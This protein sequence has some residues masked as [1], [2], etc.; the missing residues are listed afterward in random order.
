MP[1]VAPDLEMSRLN[2]S[3]FISAHSWSKVHSFPVSLNE[4][5]ELLNRSGR[6][7]TIFVT[8]EDLETA[9]PLSAR[10]DA[11]LVST[12]YTLVYGFL[13]GKP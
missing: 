8:R 9:R 5:L 2:A 6:P 3:D 13:G 11:R 4:A 10:F 7:A 12:V 1:G